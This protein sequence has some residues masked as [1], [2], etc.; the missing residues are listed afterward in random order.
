MNEKIKKICCIGA[1]YVGGPSMAI[2]A[3]KCKTI[4]FTVVDIDELRIKNWNEENLD[5]LPV[6]EPGLDKI[7]ERNRGVNLFFS[8]NVE[9]SISEADIIF[10]AVNTPIKTEGL[11]AGEARILLG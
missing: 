6:Y 3:E 7:V 8:T 11:G 2:M 1:G 9:N 4:Q 10:I 5:L